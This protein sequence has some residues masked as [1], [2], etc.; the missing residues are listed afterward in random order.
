MRDRGSRSV[1]VWVVAAS[2]NLTHRDGLV[3]YLQLLWDAGQ[4]ESRRATA[5]MAAPQV[6]SPHAIPRPSSVRQVANGLPV[7]HSGWKA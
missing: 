7:G 1:A 6:E 4:L 2:S 3:L 5:P